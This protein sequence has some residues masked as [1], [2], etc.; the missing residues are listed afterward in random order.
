LFDFSKSGFDEMDTD[1]EWRARLGLRIEAESST[2]MLLDEAPDAVDPSAEESTSS[3]SAR[4]RLFA[5][6]RVARGEDK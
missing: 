6:P 5:P 1:F 2:A 3:I 4:R